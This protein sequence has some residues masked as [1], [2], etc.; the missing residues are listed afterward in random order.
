MSK[1]L[2]DR[3]QTSNGDDLNSFIIVRHPFY[4]LV[5][6]Y[7]DKIERIHGDSLAKDWYYKQYGSKMVGKYRRLA[8]KKFGDDFFS[9]SNNFGSPVPLLP[10]RKRDANLPIFWEFVQALKLSRP[11]RMDEHWQPTWQ[12]CSLCAV[13]YK[14]VIKFETI[15]DESRYLKH[16]LD[17]E[18]TDLEERWDN[19]NLTGMK[20]DDLTKKYFEQLDDRD[21]M[22][23][24]KIYEHDFKLFGYEFSFRNITLPPR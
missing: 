4:R 8:V 11:S 9:E 22:D 3:H 15:A 2:L 1:S 5:S 16:V 20:Y 17:P 18:H 21:I 6:A 14:T 23:L 12:Y 10:G 24:Y 19:P 7:R 13:N